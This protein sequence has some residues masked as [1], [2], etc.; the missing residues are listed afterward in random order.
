M[1]ASRGRT[2]PAI[3]KLPPSLLP[4][5]LILANYR[6]LSDILETSCYGS[7][8]KE[9]LAVAPQY[10]SLAPCAETGCLRR[11]PELRRTQAAASS[12]WV[13]RLL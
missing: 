10:A 13:V 12:L 5:L 11:M 1:V 7:S 9:D 6:R 8:E 3:R 2:C 4:S